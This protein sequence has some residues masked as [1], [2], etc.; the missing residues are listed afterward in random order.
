MPIQLNLCWAFVCFFK[1]IFM[2]S[3]YFGKFLAKKKKKPTKNRSPLELFKCTDCKT[4]A[5][6]VCQESFNVLA[7]VCFLKYFLLN[8]HIICRYLHMR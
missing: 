5:Q 8:N 1:S 4:N 2:C 3:N 6:R 7:R